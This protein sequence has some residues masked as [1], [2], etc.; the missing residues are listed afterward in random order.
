MEIREDRFFIPSSYSRIVAREL[1][2]Q[3]RELPRLLRGTGLPL[4]VLL[5]GDESLMTGQQQ[6]QVLANARQLGRSEDFGLR[7]GRRL[8]P[9][10]HGPIGYLAL[11]SPDLYTAL[12]SLRDFLPIRIPFAQLELREGDRALVCSLHILLPAGSEERRMLLESFVLVIQA[13]VEAFLGR[14]LTEALV[15][16]E[17]ER[18]AYHAHYPGYVHSTILF[19]Q[20]RSQV[21][22]PAALLAE[23]NPQGDY[24]SYAAAREMCARLLQQVPGT[25]LSATD[26]VKRFLLDQPGGS[27]TE[28]D[29][30]RSL[31]VSK[32]T[33]ARRL[34]AEG[35]GYR[36]IRDEVFAEMA[37]LHLKEGQLSVESIAALL[38]FHDSANFRRAFR[39]WHGCSPRELRLGARGAVSGISADISPP[40]P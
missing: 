19:G 13:I 36:Q 33:L 6:L 34:K 23:V 31:Y 14:R 15:S 37:A 30:A 3:E 1:G 32:R 29:V 4:E 8:D 22:L 28:E 16:F 10:S 17:F 35:S 39:R 38:G 11:S 5:A 40:A 20:S 27:V 21:L 18:P 24:R 12:K 7:L 2:L 25:A 26:R 9:A